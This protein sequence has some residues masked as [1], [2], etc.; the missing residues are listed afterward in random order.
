MNT[1]MSI[2]H[3][4]RVSFLKACFKTVTMTMCAF[5]TKESQASLVNRVLPYMPSCGETTAHG[6]R[7]HRC[8]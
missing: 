1:N 6:Y 4:I 8:P 7:V 3:A 2:I 5:G